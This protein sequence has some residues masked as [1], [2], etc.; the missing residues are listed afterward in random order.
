MQNKY[1]VSFIIGLTVLAFVLFGVY[2]SKTSDKKQEPE[3]T[4][5]QTI[6]TENVSSGTIIL[7][8]TI[9]QFEADGP[10]GLITIDID[11]GVGQLPTGKYQ[12]GSWRVERK[13]EQNNTWALTGRQFSS[14][15]PFEITEGGQVNVNVGEPIIAVVH[16]S[17]IGPKYYTFS[18]SLQSR[19]DE[20]ITLTRNG[21][22]PGAPK[23]RIKN[24]D[25]TYDRTFAFRYG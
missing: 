17:R 16:G 6:V 25:G 3:S 24:K 5:S 14:G 11:Q 18:Q 2:R 8:E 4:I 22:R 21:S 10:D 7:P 23:L 9:T 13:D 20:S 19:L 15:E 12:T 1:I